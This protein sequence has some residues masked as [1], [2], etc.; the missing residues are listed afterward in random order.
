M[1]ARD[2]GRGAAAADRGGGIPNWKC[3]SCGVVNHGDD[4]YRNRK[5]GISYRQH[6]QR[7]HDDNLRAKDSA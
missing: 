7:V 3:I 1:A 4:R 2:G 6:C 5:C